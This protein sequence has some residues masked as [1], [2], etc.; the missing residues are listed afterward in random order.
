MNFHCYIFA[1]ILNAIITECFIPAN[2]MN[3][4]LS[5][6]NKEFKDTLDEIS[7]TIVHEII[8]A[9]GKLFATYVRQC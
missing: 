4:I 1:F 2:L 7:P 3:K 5:K 9:R 8:I 6:I